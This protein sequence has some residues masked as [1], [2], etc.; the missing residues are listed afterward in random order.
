[1]GAVHGSQGVLFDICGDLEACE[2]GF[3][4]ADPPIQFFTKFIP[5][6]NSAE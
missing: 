1:M 5:D 3:D 6:S 2:V 4:I